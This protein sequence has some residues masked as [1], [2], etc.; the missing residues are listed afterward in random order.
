MAIDVHD[1]EIAFRRVDVALRRADWRMFG[2][3]TAKLGAELDDGAAYLRRADWTA[4]LAQAVATEEAPES[5]TDA[6]RA[7]VA[8]ILGVEATVLD[9]RPPGLTPDM[10]V[11]VLVD[12]WRGSLHD[13]ERLDAFRGWL[14]RP[15]GGDRP[16]R[17]QLLSWLDDGCDLAGLCARAQL[18]LAADAAGLGLVVQGW[19]PTF[20][21]GL[22]QVLA[23]VPHPLPD[24]VAALDG[25]GPVA[26]LTAEPAAGWRAALAAYPGAALVGPWDALVAPALTVLPLAGSLGTCWCWAC[27]AEVAGGPGVLAVACP[28][29]GS[30]CWPLVGSPDQ[31]DV[32]PAPLRAAWD[33]ARDLVRAAATVVLLDPPADP[34]G[35]AEWARL[36]L[37]DDARVVVVGD[38][39]AQRAWR[40]RLG[41]AHR[42][43][44]V[45]SPGP[46]ADV[47]GFLLQGGVAEVAPARPA[48]SKKKGRR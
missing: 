9:A 2:D 23:A 18:A 44:F 19:V 46:V 15:G 6:L 48:F 5:A 37:R 38:E 7:A 27:R 42:D 39:A 29:C 8:R 24:L 47:L 20:Y 32:L 41:L 26:W 33:Q 35:A 22:A 25:L 43:A 34:P 36:A 14:E 3:A 28:A 30:A 13:P 21:A 12:L 4:L 45:G 16:A 17:R 40:D 11:L 10:P 1:E 31:P